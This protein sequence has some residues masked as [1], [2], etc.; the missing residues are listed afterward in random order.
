MGY[1]GEISTFM[2][3]S[4]INRDSFDCKGQKCSSNQSKKKKKKSGRQKKLD[5]RMKQQQGLREG[6]GSLSPLY[7]L[8]IDVLSLCVV[9]LE[10]L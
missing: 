1:N 7:I 10:A 5:F 3:V 9:L 4:F 8:G 6:R 2:F